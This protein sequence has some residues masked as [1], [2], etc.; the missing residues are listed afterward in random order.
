M[1]FS[2]WQVT[3]QNR[4]A[5]NNRINQSTFSVKVLNLISRSRRKTNKRNSKHSAI[6]R[7]HETRNRMFIGLLNNTRTMDNYTFVLYITLI[8]FFKENGAHHNSRS[9]LTGR[10]PV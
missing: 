3:S 10:L 9:F 7:S 4:V 6:L 2:A 1:T 8:F 5:S